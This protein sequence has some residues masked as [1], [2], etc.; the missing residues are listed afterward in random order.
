MRIVRG[1]WIEAAVVHWFQKPVLEQSWGVDAARALWVLNWFTV[2]KPASFCLKR[3]RFT[4]FAGLKV[5]KICDFDY[6]MKIRPLEPL[7]T[8]P[9]F[10]KKS[11]KR[12]TLSQDGGL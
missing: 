6:I 12:A 10:K 4:E 5:L 2:K 1:A 8:C 3:A 11:E 7:Q 9:F